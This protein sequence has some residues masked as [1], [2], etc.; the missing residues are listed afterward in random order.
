M[1]YT[2][3]AL[4]LDQDVLATVAAWQRAAGS[5]EVCGLFAVDGFGGQRVMRLTNHAGLP[6]A[7]ETSRS[8]EQTAARRSG[9]MG[10]E[11]VASSAYPSP[12]RS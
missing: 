10:L 7:F 8:E 11:I 2:A 6:G 4:S 12:P 9:T 3:Q 5:L 1:I